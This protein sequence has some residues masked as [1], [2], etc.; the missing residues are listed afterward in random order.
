MTLQWL[1]VRGALEM[2][3]VLPVVLP[4][5]M[6]V[7][8]S[9]A[10]IFL[11]VG[12][13]QGRYVWSFGLLTALAVAL[14]VAMYYPSRHRKSLERA[15][16]N[17]AVV[18]GLL[19]W[20]AFNA[21]YNAQHLITNRDP[22]TYTNAAIWLVSHRSL[23]IPVNDVFG[24]VAGITPTSP[25]FDFDS[26]SRYLLAQGQHLLP[27]LLGLTGRIIGIPHML[28]VNIFFGIIGLLAIYGFARLLVR[29]FWAAV[30]TGVLACSMPFIYFS[31]DTYT[32][33]LAAAFT[34][35]GLSLLWL[36]LQ[37]KN[38]SLWFLAGIVIGAGTL[39]RIDG[40]VTILCVLGFLAVMLATAPAEERNRSLLN[41]V[42]IIGGMATTAV[43]GWL[44]ISKL[45]VTYY[46]NNKSQFYPV[47]LAVVAVIAVAAVLEWLFTRRP[48]L[49]PRIDKQTKE[50]RGR[51]AGTA[52]LA[53]A[54]IL[55]SRPL[56]LKTYDHS[57]GSPPVRNFSELT[58]EWIAWYIGPFMA[59][60][61]VLG[62]AAAVAD[63]IKRRSLLLVAAV[64]VVGGTALLYL[65]KPS[66]APDQIWASRR[67]VPI[68]LPGIAVF[69][70]MAIERLE[71]EYLPR[72]KWQTLYVGMAALAL[73]MSP[74]ITSRHLLQEHDTAFLQPVN[75]ICAALPANAAVLWVGI[76]RSHLVQPTA[77]ICGLPSEGYG[78]YFSYTEIPS[79][80]VQNA[81][82]QSALSAGLDP[83]IALYGS[84]RNLLPAAD[85]GKMTI[86]SNFL[87]E[88]LDN[89]VNTP[90]QGVVKVYDSIIM[91]E[92]QPDGGIRPLPKAS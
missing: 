15:V 22:G 65:I 42:M 82:A 76:A 41:S 43:L 16:A 37:Q 1:P 39:T 19:L 72:I 51:A 18:G 9:I 68:I 84:Q 91:G 29:P 40:Y 31:R 61:G 21:I 92:L 24:G 58:T 63:I 38:L 80:R 28:Q 81:A 13:L 30:I 34:F 56:W 78:D 89:P 71:A 86:V 67:L 55:A 47:L 26:H 90:P 35:G 8:G 6:A 50:W 44:D 49:L 62:L 70:A 23:N 10:M 64:M 11:Q 77:G 27:V 17:L 75:D 85:Q 53:A 33:P 45:S 5:A 73:L 59:L 12:Q 87:Y 88:S 69:G 66:I 36:A 46:Q 83:V 79:T 60:L 4:V 48:E 74:L 32:E 25:G 57:P 7:F 20:G 2:V 14:L 52:V 54:L 3:E